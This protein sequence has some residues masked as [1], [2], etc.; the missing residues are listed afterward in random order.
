MKEVDG[1]EGSRK[2]REEMGGGEEG[3]GDALEGDLPSDSLE[4]WEK[5]VWDWG[6]VEEEE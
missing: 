5:R 6:G 3:E 2:E 1:D 4:E